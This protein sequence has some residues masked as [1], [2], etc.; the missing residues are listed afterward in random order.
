MTPLTIASR[1]HVSAGAL[2]MAT[3]RDGLLSSDW[4][5]RQDTSCAIRSPVRILPG[6]PS[7]VP[8]TIRHVQMP[9]S[10]AP[11]VGMR[12][13]SQGCSS[14]PCRW[15]RCCTWSRIATTTRTGLCLHGRHSMSRAT[16]RSLR[17][18]G[19]RTWTALRAGLLSRMR[20][21]RLMRVASTTATMLQRTHLSPAR[22]SV[23][24]R[25]TATRLLAWSDGCSRVWQRH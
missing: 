21:R 19:E 18:R 4:S 6:A 17:R 25:P 8:S 11:C 23:P 22:L 5:A 16:D 24:T 3:A 13:G 12:H 10:C 20:T 14:S 9:V 15:D 2:T 1:S 7:C